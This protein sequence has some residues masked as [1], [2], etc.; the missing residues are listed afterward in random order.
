MPTAPTLSTV[1]GREDWSST[2]IEALTLQSAL[3]RSNATRITTDS[4]VVHVPRLKVNP[5]AAWV[6]ELSPIP[7][8]GGDADTLVLTPRKVGN[9]LNLSNESIEDA[10]VDALN[11]VGQAMTRG[12]AT[13]VDAAAFSSSAATATTPA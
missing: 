7:S 12:V 9:A 8:D 6:A 10:S 4:R 11:A 1:W 5:A 3:L 13:R 2:L